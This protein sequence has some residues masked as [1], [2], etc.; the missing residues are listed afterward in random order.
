MVNRHKLRHVFENSDPGL[1]QAVL[2]PP[3]HSHPLCRFAVWLD[4]LVPEG[5]TDTKVNKIDCL[6]PFHTRSIHKEIGAC[7]TVCFLCYLCGW[8][9]SP[10]LPCHS[11]S[12]FQMALR[13]PAA[14]TVQSPQKAAVVSVLKQSLPAISSSA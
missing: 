1:D 10:S 13:T 4:V 9:S 3:P 11:D 7:L 12:S 2:C 6:H 5:D 8:K 14:K